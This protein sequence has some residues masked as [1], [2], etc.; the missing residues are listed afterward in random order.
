MRLSDY[1]L[2]DCAL[3]RIPP[4]DFSNI[5]EVIKRAMV[6]AWKNGS[7]AT[8]AVDAILNDYS[9]IEQL[10]EQIAENLEFQKDAALDKLDY[11]QKKA[12]AA[13]EFE[14]EQVL[15]E[16]EQTLGKEVADKER[17]KRDA[18]SKVDSSNKAYTA[19]QARLNEMRARIEEKLQAVGGR[20]AY[21]KLM[22]INDALQ[23]G[24]SGPEKKKAK[25]KKRVSHL[26]VSS[27]DP[28]YA[29]QSFAYY[30]SS[31]I[32]RALDLATVKGEIDPL[33]GETLDT[34]VEKKHFWQRKT[35][36]EQ[37]DG[38]IYRFGRK[39]WKVLNYRLF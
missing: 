28:A 8:N 29:D 22:R 2:A 34:L 4:I 36:T 33:E 18:D 37:K 10:S 23:D 24:Y 16:I 25:R 3:F 30:G 32:Q 12:I 19:A 20:E 21:E 11:Q 7:S 35:A 17:A 26:D 39:V 13:E 9:I 1:R 31:N 6:D 27:M 5:D 15:F 38:P 14:K